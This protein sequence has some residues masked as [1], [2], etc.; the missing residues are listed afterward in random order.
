MYLHNSNIYAT[1]NYMKISVREY[2]NENGKSLFSLWFNRLKEPAASKVAVALY[3]LE[4]G[5]LSNVKSLGQGLFEYKIAFGPGYRLY[6]TQEGDTLI[7]LF[8]GGTKSNQPKDIKTA[9]QLL[10]DYKSRKKRGDISW[11]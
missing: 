7:I 9:K 11:H 4:Q 3:R 5:N 8:G 1:I 10:A 6:F 2:L